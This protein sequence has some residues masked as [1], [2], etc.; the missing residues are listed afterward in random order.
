MVLENYGS[1]RKGSDNDKEGPH[2]RW[3]E[4]VLKNEGHVNPSVEV[5]VKVPSW[6][7]IVNEKGEM[8]MMG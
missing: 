2:S 8:T 7:K 6:D 1:C 5:A 3:V 4:E